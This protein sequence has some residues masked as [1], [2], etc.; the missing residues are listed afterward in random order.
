MGTCRTIPDSLR[1]FQTVFQ[2]SWAPAGD[3]KTVCDGAKTIWA[4]AEDNQPV[5]DGARES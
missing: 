3:F 4:P 2:I 1:R 5:C